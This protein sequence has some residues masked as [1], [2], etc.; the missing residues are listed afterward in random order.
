MS[1]FAHFPRLLALVLLCA[2]APSLH[3]QVDVSLDIPRRLFVCYEPLVATVTI[4]NLTGRDITLEDQAP[5]KWFSF[6]VLD[7]KGMPIPPRAADYHNPPLIIPTGQTVKRKVNIVNLYPVTDY[8]SYRV[9]AIIFMAATNKYYASPAKGIEITEGTTLWQQIVGIPDGEKN[10]G[11]NR[12]YELLSFQ[13]P[14]ADMLYVRI[15][16]KD[17]GIDYATLPLGRLVDGY[18]PEVQIDALSQLHI[19]QMIAPKEYLYTRLGPNAE[20]LG[21]DDYTDLKTR[22]HLRHMA[23]GNVAVTGGYQVQ[24]ESPEE[25]VAGPKLS[26]RPPGMPADQ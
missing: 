23:D 17:Q 6:E 14:S 19:L 2:A 1:R 7:S 4:S 18:Q 3:A 11:Q 9:R 8:G 12:T 13:Q 10:A 25:A 5:D 20:M 15:E 21:Q 26:D 22:P 24:P 16:D